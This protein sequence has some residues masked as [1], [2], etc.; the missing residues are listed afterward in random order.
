[1]AFVNLPWKMEWPGTVARMGPAR[2]APL[3]TGG[4]MM[5]RSRRPATLV[6]VTAAAV[7]VSVLMGCSAKASTHPAKVAGVPAP[8]GGSGTAQEV[9]GTAALNQGGGAGI[10]SVSCASAGNCSAGGYYTDGSGRRQV[11]VVSETGGTWQNAVEVPGM[12]VLNRGGGAGI[13]SVSCASAGN[14][15]AGGSY[16]DRSGHGQAFV[17]SEAGG[18]WQNAVEVP[19]TATLNRGGGAVIG[20]VSCASAGNCSAG[21][22]YTDRSG[23]GQAFVVSEAGGTWQ[24][25]VEVPGAA[26]L[27]RG[28]NAGIISVSCASAGTCSADGY[29]I[30]RSDRAGRQQ[31]FYDFS[32]QQVFVVSEA[33]ETWQTAVE[34][35]RIA[36]LNRGGNAWIYSVSC[37]SAGNCSAGGYYTDRSGHKL[38]FVVG[39]TGGTWQNASEVPGTAA[40]N[41]G[42]NAEIYSVS[43]ASAG[44][45][46]AG[47]YY[48]DRSRHEQ[49]FV[50]SET[51]GTWQK[52]VEVPGTSALNQDGSA[53][54]Y[55]VSCASAGNCSAGGYY[56]DRSGRRQ[57]FVVSETGGTWRKAVEVPGTSALNQ[58]GSAWI[59]SVSCASAGN[60][61]AG[62]TYTDR[63]GRYQAFVVSETGGTWH[64]GGL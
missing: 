16:T 39:E 13:I 38:A 51:G 55:S 48:T 11:F 5:H 25:A 17:V 36:A 52:A 45:C 34:V 15:S 62:G 35:P 57:V 19:G 21:G 14:C 20:S 54:I 44:N 18:T 33:G 63:S 56:T 4:S 47:G 42:G 41:R 30:D 8:V 12:A 6:L 9:P 43:C 26:T 53:W 24:N 10:D 7:G 27:N 58:D 46:S 59:Y 49:V 3:A 2:R 1:M 60:C 61:S 37:A 32:H 64:L 22:S 28:G 29:Y 31:V 40:L 23:H 50:V